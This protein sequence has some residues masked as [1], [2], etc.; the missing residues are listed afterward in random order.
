MESY[1]KIFLLLNLALSFY[2]AGIVWAHEIEIFRSWKLLDARNFELVQLTHWRKIPYW[3]FLPAVLAL[4]GSIKLMWYHPIDSPIWALWGNLI[5]Q[6]ILSFLT[7]LLWGRWQV[8]LIKERI[9]S[10][11]I[12]FDKI[13][14]THWIRTLLVNAHAIILLLWVIH[15]II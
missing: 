15:L 6:L 11:S 8:K 13:L 2:N 3:V 14:K 5:C 10:E 4:T 7:I 9:G 1:S 12:Y